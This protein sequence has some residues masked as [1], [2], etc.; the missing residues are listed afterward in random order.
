M[1]DV[2]GRPC[3]SDWF[4]WFAVDCV[5]AAQAGSQLVGSGN[6][7]VTLGLV[8][9]I[10]AVSVVVAIFGHET[11]KVLATYGAIAF[12]AL[13]LLLF[14]FLAPQFHWTL[15]PTVS[16]ADYPGAFVL[17]FM[18]CFALAPSSAPYP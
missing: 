6:R 15:G 3:R 7:W 13:S 12:A 14:I 10:A 17:G 5:I 1:S 4:G 2:T 9:V 8:L 16:G 11:I 18:T